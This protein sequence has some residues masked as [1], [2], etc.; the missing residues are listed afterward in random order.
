MTPSETSRVIGLETEY[1]ITCASTAAG[2]A[3]MNAE[4]AAAEL[5]APL[6]QQYRS[7][8]V[9]LPNGGRM[10][11]DVGSHPEYATAECGDPMTLLAHD[12][13]GDMLFAAMLQ[14]VNLS[15]TERGMP[16]VLHL[17]RNN[18][19][20]AGNSCGCHE[21]YLI[22]R[23][24]KFI[25]NLPPLI[26][27]L[28]TRQLYT[29]AGHL[30]ADGRY[31][32]SQRPFVIND[33]YSRAT[34]DSKPIVNTRDEPLSGGEKYRRLHI[35]VGDSNVGQ[36]P[37]Y[38][39]VATTTLL[40]DALESGDLDNNELARLELADPLNALREISA[41]PDS[42]V[43]T[44][45]GEHLKAVELQ[46]RIVSMLKTVISDTDS[47]RSRCLIEW[48]ELLAALS[49]GDVESITPKVD[50][51][52]KQRILKQ[53]QNRAD[54]KLSHNQLLR[55]ELAYHEI[56][57]SGLREKMEAAGLLATLLPGGAAESAQKT[58][59]KNTRANIRGKLLSAAERAG[60]GVAADWMHIRFEP[61]NLPDIS[62]ED[63]LEYDSVFSR[64]VL[65]QLH[66]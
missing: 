43:Q 24:K 55:L 11:L 63:P 62:L 50:Y 13:A 21:N 5:F 29:G 34:T 60:I 57:N 42:M 17:M 47:W 36:Y 40:L 27:H 44:A 45:A 19:D 38:M 49:A 65:E 4:A 32:L 41:N 14:Q 12:R 9:F 54:G 16:G 26:T 18:L 15:L 51:L 48:G 2:V 1:G 53:M 39:K 56:G 22:R 64:Q 30:G 6:Q 33:V 3:P 37:T 59:P 46:L 10:Y 31:Y 20:A 28:V 35:I 25:N 52:A 23:D 58:P 8:N 66:G 7:T 61:E